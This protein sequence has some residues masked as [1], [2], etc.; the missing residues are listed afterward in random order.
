[1]GGQPEELLRDNNKISYSLKFLVSWDLLIKGAWVTHRCLIGSVQTFRVRS[2]WFRNE[3]A[4]T[5]HLFCLL[6]LTQII[7]RC[8]FTYWPAQVPTK[9]LHSSVNRAL[10]RYRK[11]HGFQSRWNHLNFS[12]VCKR[13]VRGSLLHFVHNLHFKIFI[14]F[15]HK[16]EFI[17]E[18]FQFC[19][20]KT[21]ELP[22]IWM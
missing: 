3:N 14:S 10:S 22:K 12:G 5:H 13:Q 11:G 16:L 19:K 20:G 6:R 8:R 2:F 1:M 7:R 18:F 15:I 17:L 21:I 4:F 9:W